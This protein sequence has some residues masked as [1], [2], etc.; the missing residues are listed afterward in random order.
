MLFRSPF[1]V[2]PHPPLPLQYD[3][4]HLRS[5]VD[6][7]LMELWRDPACARSLTEVAAQQGSALFPDFVGSVLNDLIYLLE[8]SLGRL[9][10]G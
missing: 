5:L 1:S 7:L 10:V 9:Q 6:A 4:F 8:D 3:K 2:L